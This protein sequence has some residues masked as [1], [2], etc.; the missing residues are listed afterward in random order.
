VKNQTI[1]TEN[2]SGYVATKKLS[3]KKYL[4]THRMLDVLILKKIL[5]LICKKK[6]GEGERLKKIILSL[7]KEI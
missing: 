2:C 5:H 1:K 7:S 4:T 6:S 3:C